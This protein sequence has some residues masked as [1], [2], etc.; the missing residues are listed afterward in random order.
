MVDLKIL[1]IS[2][3]LIGIIL[4]FFSISQVSNSIFTQFNWAGLMIFITALVIFVPSIKYQK[5]LPYAL[6]A[7]G[8]LSM[9]N[10]YLYFKECS[11]LKGLEL[12]G[13][14]FISLA[15]IFTKKYSKK[16]HK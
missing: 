1:Y 11:T 12:F 15:P 3:V 8:L 4:G 14:F 16:T 9:L 10:T 7:L 6:F 13:G 5:Y 2:V